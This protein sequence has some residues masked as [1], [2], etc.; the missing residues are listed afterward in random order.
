MKA[1][2]EA[3][4]VTVIKDIGAEVGVVEEMG[5][6]EDVEEEGEEMAHGEGNFRMLLRE[7][8]EEFH[9]S[10]FPE[11]Y[12]RW[13]PMRVSTSDDALADL[14]LIERNQIEEE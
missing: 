5:V 1:F 10:D 13:T 6:I 4:E 3:V 8:Q 11:E 12:L 7:I 14:I 2:V 9:F